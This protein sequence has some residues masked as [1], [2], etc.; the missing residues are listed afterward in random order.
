[1]GAAWDQKP[2]RLI[3]SAVCW[4]NVR[5]QPVA[6]RRSRAEVIVGRPM[7]LGMEGSLGSWTAGMRIGFMLGLVKVAAMPLDNC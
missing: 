1:M 4:A 5:P 2:R 3:A 7:E 6:K